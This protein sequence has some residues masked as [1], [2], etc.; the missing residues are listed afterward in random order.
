MP[1]SFI[2]QYGKQYF[3]SYSNF[4]DN[5]KP[6]CHITLHSKPRL[7]R[8]ILTNYPNKCPECP[9]KLYTTKIKHLCT[10]LIKTQELSYFLT[11]SPLQPMDL[12]Q[13]RTI[14]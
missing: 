13:K 12:L 5:N 3:L 14:R 7:T 6:E 11:S 9:T 1:E 4:A 10:F 2:Q 8:I